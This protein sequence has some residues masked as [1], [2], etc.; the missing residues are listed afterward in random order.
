[1]WTGNPAP[2]QKKIKVKL[3]PDSAESP[4][5]REILPE[6]LETCEPNRQNI[7]PAHSVK[8]RKSEFWYITLF[9]A[10]ENLDVMKTAAILDLDS[11]TLM[12]WKMQR[13]I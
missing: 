9:T 5:C 8:K 1:M 12:A 6:V 13:N 3:L 2:N 11:R 7:H 4:N 10:C